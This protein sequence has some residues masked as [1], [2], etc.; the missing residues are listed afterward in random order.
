MVDGQKN[1]IQR[2]QSEALTLDVHK[3]FVGTVDF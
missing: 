2:R 3:V 1:E